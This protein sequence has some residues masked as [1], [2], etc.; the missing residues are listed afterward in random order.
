[1]NL[2]PHFHFQ[3]LKLICISGAIFWTTMAEL[4]LLEKIVITK[5]QIKWLEDILGLLLS[6]FVKIRLE[7]KCQNLHRTYNRRSLILGRMNRVWKYSHKFFGEL[8]QVIDIT[9]EGSRLKMRFSYC[10][11][12]PFSLFYPRKFHSF[13]AL[14]IVIRQDMFELCLLIKQRAVSAVKKQLIL[15][16]LFYDWPL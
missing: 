14:L 16:S 9:L 3:S 7:E 2:V 6:F 12:P 15:Q 8:R 1:M 5:R 11:C 4:K 13:D 10:C